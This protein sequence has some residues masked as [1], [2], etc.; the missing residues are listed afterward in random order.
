MESATRGRR[1]ALVAMLAAALAA[2]ALVAWGIPNIYHPDEIFQYFEQAHRVLFGYGIVPWEH[3]DNVRSWLLPG[4]IAGVTW[5]ATRVSEAPRFYVG[6]VHLA[7]A[8][9]SLVVVWVGFQWG[10]RRGGLRGAVLTGLLAAVWFEFVYFGSRT[11]TEM[12]AGHLLPLGIWLIWP[13]GPTDDRKRLLWGGLVLGFVVLLRLQLSPGV[14][15]AALWAGR[16]HFRTRWLPIA[17]GGG[18]AMVLGGIVDAITLSYPLQSLYTNFYVNTVENRASRFGVSPWHWYFGAIVENWRATLLVIVPLCLVALRRDAILAA[19]AGA[20]VFSHMLV[21]HK[22]YRFIYPAVVLLVILAGLG[23]TRVAEWATE[24]LPRRWPRLAPIALA[25]CVLVGMSIYRAYDRFHWQWGP[26]RAIIL[27]IYDLQAYDDIQAVGLV[28]VPWWCSGGQTYLH[29]D[30]PIYHLSL[31][32]HRF[33]DFAGSF[34]YVVT[35]AD[36]SQIPKPFEMLSSRPY[37]GG[38]RIAIYKRGGGVVEVED[39]QV[40][41]IIERFEWKNKPGE[42]K[43][44]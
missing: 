41:Q 16:T 32:R 25:A 19:V 38:K 6:A 34:N 37:R 33:D 3:H 31:D 29:R 5:L 1:T 8:A 4:F 12:A 36:A 24:R 17:A 14:A 10:E 40:E 20:I 22:E 21:P 15:V 35:T 26:Q 43:A 2:R 27:S 11:L 42:A 23:A 39:R 44:D 9:L 18:L 30:V 13:A 7:M 28:N